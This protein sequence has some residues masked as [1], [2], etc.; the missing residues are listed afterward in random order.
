MLSLD[1]VKCMSVCQE[2]DRDN[3]HEASSMR[4]AGSWQRADS[5]LECCNCCVSSS[6]AEVSAGLMLSVVQGLVVQYVLQDPAMSCQVHSRRTFLWTPWWAAQLSW[7][8]AVD[9]LLC[10]PGKLAEAQHV[11]VV[12]DGNH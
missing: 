2:V 4:Q 10:V 1:Q 7:C 9:L 6:R 5:C 11:A 8:D 3:L 12:Q